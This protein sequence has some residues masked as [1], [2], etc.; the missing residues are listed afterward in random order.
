MCPVV[1]F[2]RVGVHF[3][4]VAARHDD[5]KLHPEL[6]HQRSAQLARKR[7]VIST[8]EEIRLALR[9]YAIKKC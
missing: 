3:D 1:M 6:S 7:P 5:L 8:P 9:E 4:A 2:A